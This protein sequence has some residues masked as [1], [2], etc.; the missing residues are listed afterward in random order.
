[1]PYAKQLRDLLDQIAV[2]EDLETRR[3]LFRQ[4]G[5]ALENRF[6]QIN[7]KQ[8]AV[9]GSVENTV[10]DAL[11]IIQQQLIDMLAEIKDT[12]EIAST[13]SHQLSNFVMALENKIDELAQLVMLNNE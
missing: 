6:T 10:H 7:S 9:V 12:R 11:S 8:A 1:M 5:L 2:C 4:F 13:K 3:V